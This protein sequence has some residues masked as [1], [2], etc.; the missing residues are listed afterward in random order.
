MKISLA[1]I[2]L[3]FATAIKS[4]GQDRYLVEFTDKNNTPYSISNP[5]QFLSQRALD[6]RTAQAIA[7]DSMDLP[8]DPVYIQAIAN[9][10]AQI[11]NTSKWFNA[12]IIYTTDPLVLAAIN[13]LAFVRSS[14]N[15]GRQVQQS[16]KN[17]KFEREK[18]FTSSTLRSSS[19]NASTSFN[20]GFSYDQI[21]QIGLTQ[22]HDAGYTGSG[23]LIAVL[24]AGFLDA[25]LMTCF[26]K[27]FNTNQIKYTW[28]FVDN[29][30]DVYDDHYH[31]AA[32]LSC[33]AAYVP[34]TLIGTAPDADFLLL[35]SEDAN[36][37][38]L[39][40]EYNWS[41][42]AE[43]A[44]S[45]GADIINS[46]LGYTEFDN[47]AQNHTYSDMN[48]DVNPITIAA[49][50][51]AS[52]GIL[53][54]NSAGNEGASN[55]NYIS[56]PADA[57]SILAIGAVD[58]AGNYAYFS[59]N[60]TSYDGRVKPD[61]ASTGQGAWLYSPFSNNQPVQ[62]NGTSFSSPIMA[63]ALACLWQAW[64]QKNN[65]DIIHFTERSANQFS[66]PDTLLGYGIPNFALANSL[67]NLEEYTI[68]VNSTLN[69]LPNPWSGNS[70][71]TLLYYST[72]T[73]D[74]LPLKIYDLS[75]RLVFSN[76]YSVFKSVYNKIELSPRLTRGC[77]II[78]IR[79][80]NNVSTS[81]LI[82]L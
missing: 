57:D 65:M 48:G 36:S 17:T 21:N 16:S 75:G 1:L 66:N 64:P 78:E 24:D 27:L 11:L 26:D 41:V 7:I 67:L 61:I 56:A 25:P 6:R 22:L 79:D 51:A 9:T 34:D 40:E 14:A 44:D 73:T 50:I 28:D 71:L 82:K 31:G 12:V 5:S 49:D 46:S 59:G 23:M 37:E 77:Y 54:S 33:I 13:Q 3:L 47:S 69:L 68:P 52:R 55:W 20:Y 8:V 70:P 10:G 19:N 72:S 58:L 81:K 74:A 43:F 80:Q 18:E 39:I 15:V 63:G 2:A 35:R 30:S 29:E 38:S 53:V 32:V 42:A 76:S 4:F 45:A 60:G 62:A